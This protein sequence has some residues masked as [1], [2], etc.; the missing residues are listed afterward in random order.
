MVHH[1]WVIHSLWSTQNRRASL[2]Q[3]CKSDYPVLHSSY[4]CTKASAFYKF[5]PTLG[6]V[7]LLTF[8]RPT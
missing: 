5:S 8:D 2:T 6:N 4:Q 3:V 7:N 1:L